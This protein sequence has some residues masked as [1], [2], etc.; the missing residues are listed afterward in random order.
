[1]VSPRRACGTLGC[2]TTFTYD[3]ENR[4]TNATGAKNATLKYDPAGRLYE[5]AAP[6][7]TTRFVYDGDRLVAEYSS[8]GVLQRSY[9][10]GVGVD[11]PL[12]WYEGAVSSANRR[13]LHADH[14][15]TIVAVAG[16]SGSKIE[17]NKYDPYGV[18]ASA[19]ASRFQYTGQAAIPEVGLYY[20]KARMY[21]AALGRFMQTD[22]VG[23]DDD[24][25]LY[26][27]AA[28]DP[29]NGIDPTGTECR[30]STASAACHDDMPVIEEVVVVAR[31]EIEVVQATTITL[32]ATDIPALPVPPRAIPAGAA[33]TILL[34]M[35]FNGCGD[36]GRIGA[37]AKDNV[38]TAS[39]TFWKNLK[40]FRDKTKTNGESGMKRRYYEKDRTHGDVE[41]YDSDGRHLGSADAETGKMTKPPV[42]GRKI[43]L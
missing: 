21:N 37:C 41:V 39:G 16:T 24:V 25:N 20:Y 36:S 3:V 40:P 1:M 23:Y 15:G 27:Y 31:R 28:N 32:P 38:M 9:V 17:V 10:H 33:I 5:V 4:L 43:D 13:Y 11:E 7:G 30:L 22:P 19:V 12:V 2:A 34:D 8:S 14:Q 6:S 42:P 29:V 26:A 35:I 18:T